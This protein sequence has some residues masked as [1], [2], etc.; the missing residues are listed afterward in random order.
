M[1]VISYD[2]M[3]LKQKLVYAVGSEWRKSDFF[4]SWKSPKLKFLV[5]WRKIYYFKMICHLDKFHMNNS[6]KLVVKCPNLIQMR[7]L[8]QFP[9]N[10]NHTFCMNLYLLI[11]MK[12][13]HS[14]DSHVNKPFM[15]QI[16]WWVFYYLNFK[17]PLENKLA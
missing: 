10:N 7:G 14:F 12:F 3:V 16:I 15:P 1:V 2:C 4:A 5:V 11:Q 13:F 9:V 17:M 8:C 6:K